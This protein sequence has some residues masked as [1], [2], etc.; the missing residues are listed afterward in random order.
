MS[1]GTGEADTGGGAGARSAISLELVEAF[2]EFGPAYMRWGQRGMR[3]QGASFARVRLL[4]VLACEGPRIMSDVGETL[5]VT[6]ADAEPT[7]S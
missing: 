4:N 1:K 2:N 3:D 6:A 5:G 7:S